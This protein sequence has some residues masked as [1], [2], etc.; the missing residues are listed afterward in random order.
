MKRLRPQPD[1]PQSWK[2][3]YFYDRSEIYGEISHYGYAYAYENRR[4]ETLRLLTEV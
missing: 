3:S 4:R 1:W 2:E